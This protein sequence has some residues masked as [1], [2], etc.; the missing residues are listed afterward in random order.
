VLRCKG[1]KKLT[2]SLRRRRYTTAWISGVGISNQECSV[3]DV[4]DGGM[5]LVSTLADKIPETFTVRFNATSP[6]NGRCRIVW[7]KSSSIGVKF[8]R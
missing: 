8:V 2:R 4:S 6:N 3:F 1:M 7:R 5:M